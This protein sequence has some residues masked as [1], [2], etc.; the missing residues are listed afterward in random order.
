MT[1]L[2]NGYVD[3]KAEDRTKALS[4]AASLIEETRLQQGCQ[5]YVW[6][7]DHTS[8]TRVYVYEKWDSTEDLVA[9]LAGPYYAQMLGIL[10]S[11]EILDTAVSKY[12]IAIE[13]PVYDPEGN[14]RG[15]FFTV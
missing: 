12:K 10:G 4:A 14:P 7:A 2:I 3:I 11:F 1:V 6:S 9:H 15:D 8:D 5:H 13:E